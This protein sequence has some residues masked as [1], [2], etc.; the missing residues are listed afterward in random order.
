M[1]ML[2]EPVPANVSAKDDINGHFCLMPSER[3]VRSEERVTKTRYVKV[4]RH[5]AAKRRDPGSFIM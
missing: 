1:F 5:E 2:K 4:T 3:D